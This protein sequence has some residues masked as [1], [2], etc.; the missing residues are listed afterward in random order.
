MVGVER[1][2]RCAAG[3]GISRLGWFVEGERKFRFSASARRVHRHMHR[4]RHRSGSSSCCCIVCGLM[5][6]WMAGSRSAVVKKQTGSR[7]AV[8]RQRTKRWRWRDGMT[9]FLR[10]EDVC[11]LLI[12]PP[13]VLAG[14]H[15]WV[16]LCI[17][18]LFPLRLLDAR[19]PG[20]DMA[21]DACRGNHVPGFR[22][23]W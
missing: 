18:L 14:T 8:S 15:V 6:C 2:V 22:N 17:I 12:C 23:P 19:L 13:L 16:H 10:R 3:R 1:L 5:A 4:H 7:T 20:R 21:D 11:L 9:F